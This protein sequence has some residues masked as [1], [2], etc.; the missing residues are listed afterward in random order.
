MIEQSLEYWS[1][2]PNIL[3]KLK[4]LLAEDNPINQKVAKRMLEK[5]G[6]EIMVVDNGFDVLKALEKN[7]FDLILMDVQMP[8]MDGFVA[9]KKIRELEK[10]TRKHIPVIALTAHA[11][12]GD[13]EK[14]IKAGM[15]GYVSK[16]IKFNELLEQI[17]TFYDALQKQYN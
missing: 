1:T 2:I 17:E 7:K 12:K 6:Y 10:K 11:M 9:T 16:P 8:K 5:M 13:R 4:V 14:C 15:D 3:L